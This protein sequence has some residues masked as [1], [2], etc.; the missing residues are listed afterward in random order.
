MFTQ[1][2]R[3]ILIRNVCVNTHRGIHTTA[4]KATFWEREKKS[5]Y[6]K[7]YPIISKTLVLE[8][9]KELKS[10][11]KMWKDEM[12]EKLEGDPIMVYRP[13][14]IDVAWKFSGEIYYAKH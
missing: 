4:V 9:L 6:G 14:E 13:G 7:K 1:L 2:C 10:E 11:I 8:G 5:G 12:Q 3:G